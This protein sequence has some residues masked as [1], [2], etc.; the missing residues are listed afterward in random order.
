MYL[1]QQRLATEDQ[2]IFPVSTEIDVDSYALCA[3]AAAKKYCV[4]EGNISLIKIFRLLFLLLIA[5]LLF[6]TFFFSGYHVL[7]KHTE[8]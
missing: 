5:A 1:V 8:F 6:C 4:D 2:D 3:A 7:A